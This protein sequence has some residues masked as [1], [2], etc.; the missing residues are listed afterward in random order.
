[1]STRLTA[2]LAAVASGALFGAGLVLSGMVVPSRVINFLDVTGRWDPTLAIVMAAAL[3]VAMPLFRVVTSRATPLLAARFHLPAKREIDS[4]LLLGA[5][6][7]G[8]G[9]G[10]AGFC[11]G[12]ALASLIAGVADPW[13]F[14]GGLVA[15]SQLARLLSR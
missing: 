3:L 6:L 12:P 13:I 14:A 4:P 9:W 7:F 8:A 2:L 11:P 15:G 10:I 5:A 1:V